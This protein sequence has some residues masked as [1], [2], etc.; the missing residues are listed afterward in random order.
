[1]AHIVGATLSYVERVNGHQPTT[2]FAHG[3]FPGCAVLDELTI[4]AGHELLAI[5]HGAQAGEIVREEE[6]NLG[7]EYP[8]ASLLLQEF[9]HSTEHRTQIATIITQ[10]G[11]EPPDMSG[12]EF[13]IENGSFREF[14]LASEQ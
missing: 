13:M 8:L 12:W 10:L 5:A 2:G 3:E 9:T 4:W 14:T 1:L 7:C 6:G 11:L